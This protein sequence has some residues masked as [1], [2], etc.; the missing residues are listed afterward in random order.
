L[1]PYWFFAIVIV[2]IEAYV[3][4]TRDIAFFHEEA[5]SD[6]SQIGRTLTELIE[7]IWNHNGQNRALE[8]IADANRDEPL[9]QVRLVRFDADRADPSAPRVSIET[10][11]SVRNGN[12]IEVEE[13][14]DAGRSFLFS[15]TPLDIK[16]ERPMA[17]E[18]TRPMQTEDKFRNR[19]II[20]AFIV[21]IQPERGNA[22]RKTP[23]FFSFLAFFKRRTTVKRKRYG[24]CVSCEIRS[25][26]KTPNDYKN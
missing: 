21:G 13:R 25:R 26:P 10:I 6:T 24:G 15:Y 16:S 2:A 5:R 14:N 9:V 4:I 23:I 3:S 12:P 20:R 18:I 7:D 8:L 17:L 11:R 19:T 22:N 1:F